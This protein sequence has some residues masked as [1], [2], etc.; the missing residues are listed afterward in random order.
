MKIE[1]AARLK[2]AITS[3]TADD[4]GKV[5]LW[6]EKATGVKGKKKGRAGQN[7]EVI[8][9]IKAGKD[10]IH[11]TVILEHTTITGVPKITLDGASQNS[12]ERWIESAKTGRQTILGFKNQL[13]ESIPTL[14]SEEG[15]EETV[16]V[17]QKLI[18]AKSKVE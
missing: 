1:A 16:A 9:K 2:T 11:I 3:A 13:R 7:E 14:K 15:F 4:A 12:G 18:A 6:V 5:V 10:E 17:L 8:F